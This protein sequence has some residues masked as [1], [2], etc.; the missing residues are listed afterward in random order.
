MEY[1]QMSLEGW[2]SINFNWGDNAKAYFYGCNTGL[3]PSGDKKAFNTEVSLL[4]NF[5]NVSVYGQVSYS[6]PSMYSNSRR[7]SSN[8]LN[9]V[10]GVKGEPTYLVAGNR[11]MR[12][13]IGWF[14]DT[15]FEAHKMSVRYPHEQL[16][17]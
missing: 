15:K 4:D 12:P 11:Y 16:H 8:Q 9:G 6:Y 7:P 10:F 5:K 2:G 17:L 1:N 3:D 13:W 14:G